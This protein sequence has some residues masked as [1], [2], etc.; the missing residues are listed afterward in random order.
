MALVRRH[1]DRLL[2]PRL[3]DFDRAVFQR[4]VEEHLGFPSFVR[5]GASR[6]LGAGGLDLA[7][8]LLPLEN[9]E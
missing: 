4:T 3:K 8:T 6:E 2:Y 7:G 9:A 5:A 1:R